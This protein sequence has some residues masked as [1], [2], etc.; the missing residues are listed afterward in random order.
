MALFSRE[1]MVE[2][3]KYGFWVVLGVLGLGFSKLSLLIFL[4][5]CYELILKVLAKSDKVRPS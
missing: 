3:L 5:Y 2:R 4:I 1:S